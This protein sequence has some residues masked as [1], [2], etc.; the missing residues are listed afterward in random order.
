MAKKTGSSLPPS[1]QV[2]L[3][4]GSSW[5][6]PRRFTTSFRTGRSQDCEYVIP[7]PAV[8]KMHA[9]I[10]FEDGQ[11]WVIDLQ[12][13][14][15]TYLKGQRIVRAVLPPSCRVELGQGGAIL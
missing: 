1:L 5:G 10:R 7:V 11:W 8:S 13:R 15:G 4:E 6:A 2:R 12:S 9:E 14:N 3:Q